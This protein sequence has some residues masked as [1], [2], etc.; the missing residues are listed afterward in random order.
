[1]PVAIVSSA[2]TKPLSL[3]YFTTMRFRNKDVTTAVTFSG[4][5][6]LNTVLNA[7]SASLL[8]ATFQYFKL[9]RIRMWASDIPATGGGTPSSASIAFVD[10]TAGEEGNARTY[11]LNPAGN[12]APAYFEY[13]FRPEQAFGR[14]QSGSSAASFIV[15]SSDCDLIIE[16]DVTFRNVSGLAQPAIVTG[17]GLTTG[18]HYFRG[19]DGLA[20]AN[21]KWPISCA[22][23]DAV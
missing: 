15:T 7:T 18:A 5:Q 8:T 20:I 14:W 22:G 23:G 16:L 3:E 6:I 10:T 11:V 21:T 12:A 17:T 4:A 13:K 9:K 2:P 1:M 19:L